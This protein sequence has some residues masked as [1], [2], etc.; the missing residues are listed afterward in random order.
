MDP[1]VPRGGGRSGPLHRVL[2]EAEED[3]PATSG[4]L[5]GDLSNRLGPK[6]R[7]L[8]FAVLFGVL[9][10]VGNL[11]YERLTTRIADSANAD[12]PALVGLG[13]R[14]Y[15]QHCA[16]CHGAD[17]GGQPDWDGA[18]PDGNRPA[19]PLDGRGP[20]ARLSDRD[21]FDITRFGGQPFSP[22]SYRNRMPGYEGKL[23]EP[24][25]WAVLAY[26]KSRWSP[27]TLERQRQITAEQ[28]G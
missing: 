28:D 24:E 8:A 15:E 10:T 3:A 16:Y 17:L 5:F 20:I 21:L 14:L 12:D 9:I 11:A 2:A 1:R 26:I 22:S 6:G 18:Y 13:H 25:I 4:G 27:E 23:T 19:L 7:F